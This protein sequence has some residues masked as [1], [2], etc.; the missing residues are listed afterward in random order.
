MAAVVELSAEGLEFVTARHL[1]TLTTLRL[2][3]SPHVVPVGFTWDAE[4]GIARVICTGTSQKARHAARGGPLALCQVDGGRWLTVEGT[5]TVVSERARVAEAEQRYAA[6]YRTPKENPARVVIEIAV[7]R[8][9]GSPRFRS[10]GS[11][12]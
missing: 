11:D 7:T 4:R 6:R 5:G 10:D 2:D 1:A 8:V 3:G 12:G 9:L